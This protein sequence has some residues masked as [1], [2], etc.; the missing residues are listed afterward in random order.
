MHIYSK[1]LI[2]K[3]L[4]PSR[5]TRRARRRYATLFMVL[6]TAAGVL[7]ALRPATALADGHRQDADKGFHSVGVEPVSRSTFSE[8]RSVPATS[9]YRHLIG[10]AVYS[11]ITEEEGA[12]TAGA[13]VVYTF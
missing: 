9:G 10:D 1:G 3:E 13:F 2:V 12:F 7:L 6:F 8:N 4:P 5:R 11:P